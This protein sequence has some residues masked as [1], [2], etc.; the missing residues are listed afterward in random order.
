MNQTNVKQICS[1]LAIIS[2]RLSLACIT[3]L[4]SLIAMWF[5]LRIYP[6]DRLMP[7][8]IIGYFHPWLLLALLPTV[9]VTLVS[10]KWMMSGLIMLPLIMFAVYYGPHFMPTLSDVQAHTPQITLTVMTYNLNF[11]NLDNTTAIAA[12]IRQQDADL[13][14]LQ[15]AVPPIGEPL[16][17]ELADDYPHRLV[18]DV[19]LPKA[20]LSRYPLVDPTQ[21]ADRSPTQQV[22]VETPAGPVTVWNV[23][24][25]P[26][27]VDL[28]WRIQQQMIKVVMA[29]VKQTTGPVI[30]L[31]DF[32]TVPYSQNYNLITAEL[33]DVHEVVGR[34][35]GFTFP[36]FG[37]TNRMTSLPPVVRIDHIFI[38]DEFTPQT[39]RVVPTTAGSDH[40][41]V[42]ATLGW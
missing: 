17:A 30:V 39:I 7:V 26:A 28:G 10:R 16:L 13:V 35:F 33:T 40:Y 31:G 4:T 41:P 23:H 11:D 8:R 25:P 27:V 14:A 37:E 2:H 3:L 15:E 36:N 19:G 24:P 29:E 5:M 42:V 38:S 20:I 12:L 34:G 21:P 1:N 32:N 6:G 9:I 22:W 18:L